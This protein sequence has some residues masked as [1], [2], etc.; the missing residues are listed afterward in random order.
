[1]MSTDLP[2]GHS[3]LIPLMHMLLQMSWE[4]LSDVFKDTCGVLEPLRFS[5]TYFLVLFP[6]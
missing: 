2:D 1:M 3:V 4:V 6:V 5:K